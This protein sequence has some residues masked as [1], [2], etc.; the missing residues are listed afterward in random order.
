MKLFTY[1]ESTRTRSSSQDMGLA[2]IVSL[3]L[4]VCVIFLAQHRIAT[5]QTVHIPDPNL[6]VL[7]ESVL[8]KAAGDD[9]TQVDLASLESIRNGCHFLTLSEKGV[10]WVPERWVCELNDDSVGFGIRDL[11]GLEFATNL[12]HLSLGRNQISDVSPLKDLINLTYLDLGRNQISDV[13]PL[14]DLINLTYL[15]LGRNQI[16]DV[17]PLKDLTN[18]THLSL[19][20]NRVSD[21]SPLKDLTELIELDL[22][23]NEIPDVSVLKAFT[24]LTHLSLRSNEISNISPLKDLINL[25]YLSLRDNKISDVSPLKDLTNLIYLHIGFNYRISDISPLK[26]LKNLIHLDF[27]DNEISDVSPLKDLTNLRHLDASDN[28]ISDVSPL[29]DLTNLTWLDLDSSERSG[30]FPLLDISPLKG[31]TNLRYLDLHHNEIS[32]VS[33]LKG[34][35]NLKE[36]Y[37]NHNEVS[38][39][40]PLKGLVNLKELYLNHNEISD[41]S[42]LKDLTNLTILNLSNNHISDFSPIAGLIENLA[43]YN[44]GN[45]TVPPLKVTADVNRDGV[46]NIL[47]LVL[48]GSHFHNTDFAALASSDVYP[49][50]NGDSVVDVRDLVAIAAEIGAVA[51]APT[52]RKNAAET[53]SLTAENLEQWIQL[54][55]QLDTQEPRTQRGLTVLEQLLATLTVAEVLPKETELLANYPNPFNPET[56]IPYQLAKPADVNISIYTADGKFVRT[57]GMGYLPAGVYHRK[58]HAAYWD[59]RNALGESV[60]SGVYFYTLTAGDFTATGKMLIRK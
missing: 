45:Q 55:K 51:A 46:V 41:V 35:V 15:S 53:S 18:L 23:D 56:W 7:L 19:I 14:K 43:K 2:H 21:I 54:A 3:I 36:L 28:G 29:K 8:D 59:G 37:L 44:A 42:P 40:A 30:I 38:D 49:D 17:S 31:L 47:D 26:N 52:V 50:V 16:S 34:L 6:R 57:L 27:D 25:T 9:I 22:L 32:D 1:A 39:I 10:W 12:M 58:S 20:Y 33:P 13:S 60:A 24:N 48:V 11:T 4:T 5:A